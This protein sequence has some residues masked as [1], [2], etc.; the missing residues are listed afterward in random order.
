LA[1]FLQNSVLLLYL[2]K[3]RQITTTEW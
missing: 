1:I 2:S 3:Y